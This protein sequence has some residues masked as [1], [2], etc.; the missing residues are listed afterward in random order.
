MNKK[1]R[2]ETFTE[3]VDLLFQALDQETMAIFAG[4]TAD[5]LKFYYATAGELIK[6]Q[7]RLEGG[8]PPLLDDCRKIS[9]KPD[10]D[11]DQAA[12]YIL[13]SFWARLQMIKG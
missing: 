4:R 5:E 7:F 11:G 9:G 8:N 6:I 3:A 13:E 1:Y 10:L 2:P 12:I